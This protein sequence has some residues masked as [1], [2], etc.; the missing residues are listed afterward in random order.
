MYQG[1][2]FD[3]VNDHNKN[4]RAERHIRPLQDLALFHMIHS[5]HQWSS[6]ITANLWPDEIRNMSS[7]INKIIFHCLNDTFTPINMFS[8][9]KVDSNKRHC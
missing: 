6:A 8:K 1:L 2:N 5:Y 9:H 4:G 3:G 7:V